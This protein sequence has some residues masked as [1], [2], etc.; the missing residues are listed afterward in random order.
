MNKTMKQLQNYAYWS[1][2]KRDVE[3]HVRRCEVCCRYRHGPKNKQGP[4][5]H[6]V[7][8]GPMQKFHVDLTGPHVRSKNGF[9]Y[10]LTGICQFT[11]YLV[12][13]P[14][15]DKT[16]LSVSRALVKNVYL[17]YGAV[18]LQ[19]TDQGREFC[20]EV[21]DHVAQMM[22][23]Q[24][25]RTTAYRPASNGLAERVH[26]TIHSVFAKTV[27]ETQK[28]WCEMVPYV[29]FAYNIAHHSSTSYSPFYLMFGREPR[30]GLDLLLETP[31]ERFSTNLD[32]FTE[33][34]SHRMQKA[35]Q[36]VGDHLGTAFDRAKTRYDSRVKE[37][38]FKE[39]D[40]VWYFCPRRKLRRNRKW[41]L[42]TT[43]PHL[44]T[45]RINLVNYVVKLAPRGRSLIVH[46]DRLRHYEGETPAMWKGFQEKLADTRESGSHTEEQAPTPL[47]VED[48]DTEPSVTLET[49]PVQSHSCPSVV[50][51]TPD[52]AG[53]QQQPESG[54]PEYSGGAPEYSEYSDAAR[55][56]RRIR[57]RPA[58]FCRASWNTTSL[59]SE[60]TSIDSK[61][62]IGKNNNI[63]K[64]FG[65]YKLTT[66]FKRTMF[67]CVI[68]QLEVQTEAAIRRH[69]I[70]MHG[71]RWKRNGPP[72]VVPEPELSKKRLQCRIQQAS[73]PQRRKIQTQLRAS[74]AASQPETAGAGKTL[75]VPPMTA[76]VREVRGHPPPSS[77]GFQ[78]TGDFG[79]MERWLFGDGPEPNTPEGSLEL[80]FQPPLVTYDQ[81]LQ[82]KPDQAHKGQLVGPAED[83]QEFP[84]AGITFRE[85]NDLVSQ[86]Q[87]RT[88]GQLLDVFV[89]NHPSKLHRGE[90]KRLQS[91]ITM[92]LLARRELA[93]DIMRAWDQR[94]P[95]MEWAIASVEAWM[96]AQANIFVREMDV[97]GSHPSEDS[98]TELGLPFFELGNL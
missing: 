83:L 55:R 32:D 17:V 66:E 61:Q 16:A 19:I 13:V 62:V 52:R 47:P 31:T 60:V 36:L 63:Q 78:F 10:L 95:Q 68:C 38:K 53:H 11:K 82:V 14:L 94:P 73:G 74:E 64:H 12:A 79:E 8:N 26:S 77:D 7:S 58:R 9:V 20:N 87:G 70:M 21:L 81:G 50:E 96:T 4:L 43:G 54:E 80:S 34:M 1:G 5:Q 24:P 42:M 88:S 46:V 84:P 49:T 59:L 86:N 67:P 33:E 76:Q 6:A 27:H 37:T 2:W 90:L 40:L 91:L 71:M 15:R 41:Q 45:K 44:V 51:T 56:P 69:C 85:I 57:R 72:E 93:R 23:I 65:N 29:A 28:N 98:L 39:G 22:G 3:K 89:R 92:A 97:E 30:T 48:R 75:A 25:S 35:Y 18:D